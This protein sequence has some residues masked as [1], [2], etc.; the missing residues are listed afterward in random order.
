[1]FMN[2]NNIRSKSLLP[3]KGLASLLALILLASILTGCGEVTPIDCPFTD[4]GWETTEEELL[5]AEGEYLSTYDSTYGGLT[6]TYEG[7]YMNNPGILKYMYDTE[8][9]LMS[10]AWAYSAA[11]DESLLNLYN[12]IH[13]NLEATHGKSGYNTTFIGNYGDVWELPEGDIL[14]SVMATSTNKA[15]QLAYVNPASSK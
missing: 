3:P 12:E 4:L 15:L 14:L 11:D 1:M 8:G 13:A 9:V 5:A 7:T 10:V 2:I 6:Y